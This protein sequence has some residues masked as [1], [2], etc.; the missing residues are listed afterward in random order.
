MMSKTDEKHKNIIYDTRVTSFN[1]FKTMRRQMDRAYHQMKKDLPANAVEYHNNGLKLK[2]NKNDEAAS[3]DFEKY[4]A[5]S[6]AFKN[7]HGL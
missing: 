1:N 5:I 6:S 2:L 3:K 7:I 4:Q